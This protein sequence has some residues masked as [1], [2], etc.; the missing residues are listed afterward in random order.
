VL[1]M[2]VHIPIVFFLCWFF[3][4]TIPYIAPVH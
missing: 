3:A 4:R 1:Q 2:I